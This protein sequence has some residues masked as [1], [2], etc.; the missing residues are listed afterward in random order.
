[1]DNPTAPTPAAPGMPRDITSDC[2]P[3]GTIA[4]RCIRAA[5]GPMHGS[6]V[7]QGDIWE[8][9]GYKGGFPRSP[10]PPPAHFTPRGGFWPL[11]APQRS[12]G[13]PLRPSQGLSP[14]RKAAA[15]L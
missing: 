8:E 4:R 2:M 11:L 13:S 1:M 3:I 14:R 10:A 6:W 7:P 15:G 5:A 12:S 9:T